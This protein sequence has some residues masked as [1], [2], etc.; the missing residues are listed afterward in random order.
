MTLYALTDKYRTAEAQM[1]DL[2]MDEV[3]IRDT[4]EALQGEVQEKVTSVAMIVRNLES[5]AEQIKAAEKQMAERR[6]SIE[7]RAEWLKGYLLQNMVAV[8]I[9]SVESPWFAIKVRQNPAAVTVLDEAAI[10]PEFWRTPEPP[11]PALDKKAIAETLKAG[12]DVPGATLTRGNRLE[13][14]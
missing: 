5:L 11:P 9:Q 7:A 12:G 1:T 3:T 13:I 10:P 6:K 4:L 14:K 2:G 8:G